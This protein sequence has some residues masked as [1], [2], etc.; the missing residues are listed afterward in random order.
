MPIHHSPFTIHYNLF[1]IHYSLFTI[2]HSLSKIPMKTI[3][4]LFTILALPI[5]SQTGPIQ[6]YENSS[7]DQVDYQSFPTMMLLKFE[8]GEFTKLPKNPIIRPEKGRWDSKDAADPFLMVTGD[9]ITV[10]YDGDDRGKY[11]IGYAVMDKSGWGWKKRGKIFS[12]SG[13]Q[14]DSFHQIAP[15]VFMKGRE[16]HLYYNGNSTDSELGYQW[17]LAVKQGNGWRTRPQPL[18]QLD[19]LEWDFA[20]NAYGDI[21]YL[22]KENLYRMWYTGFQ[23]PVASI[24][25]A[26]SRDGLRWRKRGKKPVFMNIPGVIAPDI[27]FDGASYTMFFTQLYLT[28]RGP[29]TK[30]SRAESADG[31]TWRNVRDVLKPERRWEK[32]KLMRPHLAYFENRI[33]L[34]YCGA[35]GGRWSIGAAYSDAQFASQGSWRSTNRRGGELLR[36]KYEVPEGT[37]LKVEIVANG[38]AAGV[39]ELTADGKELRAGVYEQLLEIP[40][41]VRNVGWQVELTFS[42]SRT[43]RSP[44]VYDLLVR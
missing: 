40:Q 42:T 19:S 1:T 39:K 20:G 9:S 29:R 24:G 5:F 43:D 35:R 21:V 11:H 30:I 31:F 36:I 18:M 38:V 7:G 27:L 14:W 8:I 32:R 25:V 23:G 16:M 10:F 13:E 3:L 15:I 17:G 34:Y 28:D 37:T 2:H 22:P 33:Y 6:F 26:D 12:G 41:A 44:I 4:L